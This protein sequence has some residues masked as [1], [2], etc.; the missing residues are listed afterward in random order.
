MTWVEEEEKQKT[1]TEENNINIEHRVKQTQNNNNNN[2]RWR[3]HRVYG[4][5][6]LCCWCVVGLLLQKRTK[7]ETV[8][9]WFGLRSVCSAYVCVQRETINHKHDSDELNIILFYSDLF[10]R[11]CVRVDVWMSC[12]LCLYWKFWS[13]TTTTATTRITLLLLFYVFYWM[14]NYG[15]DKQV[16][17]IP[18]CV[19]FRICSLARRFRALS[20]IS[21]T[22]TTQTLTSFILFRVIERRY[23]FIVLLVY[24]PLFV[25]LCVRVL[26]ALWFAVHVNIVCIYSD[27]FLFLSVFCILLIDF[28]LFVFVLP[29]CCCC[30]CCC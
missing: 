10:V 15:N 13:A 6:V 27:N 9:I 3:W 18:H 17:L 7:R 11:V 14:K 20:Q 29:C 2:N 25:L 28:W 21:T 19:K 4:A 22:G 30:C 8:G 12:V 26:G 5:C 24:W 23:P 16:L 1:T